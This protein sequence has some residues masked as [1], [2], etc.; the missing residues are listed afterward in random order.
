VHDR[1]R[2][3]PPRLSGKLDA[4][5]SRHPI[6]LAN[7]MEGLSLEPTFEIGKVIHKGDPMT[8]EVTT[9]RNTDMGLLLLR[10]G[11]GLSIFI[12][13]GLEKLTGYSRMVQHFP[14]PIHIGA[15]AGLAFA[16]LSDGIC[17]ILIVAGLFT[18]LASAVVLINL[19]TAFFFVH[20]AAYL[21][22]PHVELI[23]VYLIAVAAIFV[24]GP[25]K[26]SI[27]ARIRKA[28]LLKSPLHT[29]LR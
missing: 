25:G 20:H 13:H 4:C 28:R 7:A 19:L 27:D 15:H 12:K 10:I 26:I 1:N 16:L 2:S 3:R 24:M 11:A 9:S 22:N 17:T 23:M 18:R 21:T 14:D 8:S 5:S 29:S 6:S